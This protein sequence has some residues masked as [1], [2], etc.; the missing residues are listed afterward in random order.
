FLF[1]K[2]PDNEK[3]RGVIL[4]TPNKATEIGSLTVIAINLGEREGIYSGD[5]FRIRSQKR[6][7]KDP[8]TTEIYQIP[9]E[10]IGLAI[11]FRTFEKVSYAL[12]TDSNQQV[13]PGDVLVSPNAE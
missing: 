12:I 13:L 4:D 11:V 10:D 1:P 5:V 9:E 2:A 8:I 3:I 7:K 6:N